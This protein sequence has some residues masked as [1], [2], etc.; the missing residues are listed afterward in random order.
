MRRV[1]T[2]FP[3]QRRFEQGH[4][5]GVLSARVG[6]VNSVM[7][8][9]KGL[10]ES[11]ELSF[12]KAFQNLESK[13]AIHE[14]GLIE[15]KNNAAIANEAR[16]KAECRIQELQNEV[17]ALREELSHYDSKPTELEPPVKWADLERDFNPEH[18]WATRPT[19]TGQLRRILEGSYRNLYNNLKLYSE[20]WA[21]LKARVA[22]HKKNL[23]YVNTKFRRDKFTLIVDGEPVT[24][25]RVQTIPP[26]GDIDGSV[27]LSTSAR[28]SLPSSRNDQ[29]S[30][31]TRSTI[32]TQN[33]CLVD[34]NIKIKPEPQ[35][36]NPGLFEQSD[37]YATQSSPTCDSETLDMLP[38]L[39]DL[40]ARKRKWAPSGPVRVKNEP[41]SSSPLHYTTGQPFIGT[42]DLDD[43]GDSVK[44]PTKKQAYREVHWEDSVPSDQDPLPDRVSQ[45][46]ALRPVDGNTRAAITPGQ[47]VKRTKTI[48]PHALL[49]ITED[50]DSGDH[51]YSHSPGR[52]VPRAASK[53]TP[54]AHLTE[55]QLQG[56]LEKPTPSRTPLAPSQ[57]PADQSTR[58]AR[59]STA[60]R[61]ARR[62]KYTVQE[63]SQLPEESDSQFPPNV[64]PEDEPY[65]ARALHRL[66]LQHF[67]LN[68]E[69]NEGLDYAF[70]DVVRNK[71]DRRCLT[72]CTRPDCCGRQFRTMARFGGL[73]AKSPAE[74][75]Q[76]DQRLVEE[77]VGDDQHLLD[78]IN[79]K[80]REKLLVEART[81]ALANQ[82]GKHRH[83]HQRPQ[84]P[85]G[86][87]RTDM[88][89]T[90]ELE[91]DREAARKL[92]REKVE[93]R[94]REA[95]RPGG[96]WTWAD[97]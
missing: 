48:S 8:V 20:T 37:P 22:H 91:E 79:E 12:T 61:E 55:N 45:P 88:P 25:R 33:S 27:P 15:A 51:T 16:Q 41:V 50:G 77:F 29:D 76:E 86:F 10:Q 18:I 32:A 82:Y 30:N 93:E 28:N 75:K 54:R 9:L 13:L 40:Q 68:P 43:I 19:E 60:S 84:S 64:D 26:V 7:D 66:S 49:S 34:T 59:E 38:P 78:G 46:T 89:S 4:P 72:G 52:S 36:Q 69:R 35:S 74:Q 44:T 39:P 87:W 14:A 24:F 5:G 63:P 17:A 47:R 6:F 57:R 96:L 70:K 97:E 11:C 58:H 56:L 92:E 95:M 53:S 2:A 3:S 81:R 83:T 31:V 62:A 73:P 67:K 85:P 21:D 90:Q 1:E 23:A 42:Q 65:R 94:Y 80:E 71:D